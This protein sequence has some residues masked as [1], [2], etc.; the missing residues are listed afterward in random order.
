MKAIAKLFTSL[1]AVGVLA[2]AMFVVS[3]ARTP[4][5]EAAP[6]DKTGINW[7]V[8]PA[9]VVIYLD[10]KRLGEAGKLKFTDAKPGKHTVKL[11][12]GKDE[13]EAEIVVKKGQ[14]LKFAFSFDQG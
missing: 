6:Q 5:A 8:E 10:D 11:V 9:T 14:S 13:T 7:E 2:G 3:S 12:N 4:A 1:T